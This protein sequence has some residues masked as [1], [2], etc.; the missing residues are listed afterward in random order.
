MQNSA[1][2]VVHKTEQYNFNI[3]YWNIA[4]SRLMCEHRFA[5]VFS[6]NEGS[7]LCILMADVHTKEQRSLICLV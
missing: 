6:K 5:F 1:G 3:R 7:Y 4:G 2:Q